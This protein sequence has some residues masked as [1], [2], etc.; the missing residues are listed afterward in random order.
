[1]FCSTNIASINST[2][3]LTDFNIRESDLEF[4]T[5][6]SS[7]L[8]VRFFL[9]LLNFTSSKIFG[10]LVN[11]ITVTKLVFVFYKRI[12]PKYSIPEH[13]TTFQ[14]LLQYGDIVY[15]NHKGSPS[16]FDLSYKLNF[17]SPF[18]ALANSYLTVLTN[19]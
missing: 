18:V 8:P 9:F 11:L 14:S 5:T 6:S 7:Y 16:T 2:L 4:S 15:V 19:L 13:S 3:P 10:A 1:M 12:I 17:P